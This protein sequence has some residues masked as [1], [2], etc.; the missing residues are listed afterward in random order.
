MRDTLR[1]EAAE[2]FGRAVEV[3][4]LQRLSGGASRELWAFTVRDGDH[5]REL[6][7]RQDPP[8][9]EDPGG[10]ARELEALAAA[11]GHGVAVPEPLWLHDGGTGLVMGRAR[12]ES[13]ARRL[14]RDER[15]DRARQ[16]LP[17]QLA[18]AAA[19][20]HA[21]P[22]AEVPSLP[23]GGGTLGEIERLEGELDRIGEP[24]PALE[25]GLRWLR[26][27]QP[28]PLG[29]VLVHGDLRLGNFL[30]DERG[31]VAVLDWELCHAGDPAEDLA[32]LCVRSWRFGS[33]QRAVAGLGTRDELL[34]AYRRA[35]GAPVSR[36][37][38][39]FWEVLGNVRWGVICLVQA[40]THLSGARRSLEH[41]AIGRRTCEPE[42]D[43]LAMVG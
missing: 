5:R 2:H 17:G 29:P 34:A 11:H 25:L 37:Q 24:H 4:E 31:L 43:L 42:W 9:V 6:V 8:G 23:V 22:L 38:L 12:G 7:L 26:G 18:A 27:H 40:D 41:A 28:E 10:R 30:A 33:D 32:W 19:A 16:A 21:V 15:Y 36:E 35:G 39:R 14:L 3:E 20:I 1:A 13:I